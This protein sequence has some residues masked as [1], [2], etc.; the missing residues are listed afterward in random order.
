LISLPLIFFLKKAQKRL[1]NEA[2]G[3]DT[4]PILIC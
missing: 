2:L 3:T 1:E 4:A